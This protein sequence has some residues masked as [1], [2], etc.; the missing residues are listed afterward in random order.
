MESSIKKI[1]KYVLLVGLFLLPIFILPIF[2]NPFIVSKLSLSVGLVLILLILFAIRIALVGKLEFFVGNFDLPIL[3]IGLSFL[4]STI[5]RTPNKMEA[6]LYPGTLTAILSGVF[7]YFFINQ[8]AEEK[9]TI[10]KTLLSSGLLFSVIMLLSISDILNKIPQLPQYLRSPNFTPEGGFLPAAIFLATILPIGIGLLLSSKDIYFKI[11]WAVSSAI[12]TFTLILS[13]YKILPGK[14]LAPRFPSASTSWSIAVDSLKVSPILG[15]GPGNYLTS[16]NRFRPLS[17][18]QTD[19]WAVKFA[20]AHDFYLT[21]ITEAGL[22][23]A[24]GLI[25]LLILI[26]RIIKENIEDR[27]SLK[28][29]LKTASLV[30]LAIITLIFVLAPATPLLIILFF[31]LLSLNSNTHKAYISSTTQIDSEDKSQLAKNI[32]PKFPAL[33]ASSLII[34]GALLAA[35]QTLRIL[36]AEYKFQNALNSLARNEASKTYDTL[37]DAIATNPRVD[38][39]RSTFAQVNL[40][41]ANAI[42]QKVATNS[43]QT[44]LSDQDRQSIITLIQQAINEAKAAVALNPLRAGN[45]E[46]LGRIYRSLIPLATDADKFAIQTYTQAIALDPINP[47]LRV[48]LGGIYYS[49]KDYD[50]AVRVFELATLAKPDHANAHYN[51][52]FALR[53]RGQKGDL[54]RSIQEM[55]TVLSLV[56]KNSNDYDIAKKAL[57][58]LQAKKKAETAQGTELTAPKEEK[59]VIQPPLELPSESQPPESPLSPTP[60]PTSVSSPTPTP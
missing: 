16:F 49:R 28:N 9:E 18:N 21:S 54:D 20:T 17:Y 59:P 45:W 10:L 40:A 27:S 44:T 13:I 6:L 3:I 2:S 56:D 60:S 42:V 1:E 48:S 37:R 30:S 34:I 41:L 46:I 51:L 5:L 26:F 43:G 57:E 35:N 15:V 23:F 22:L 47:N 55:T 53:E 32:Y 25:L 58:D 50:N 4:L 19:L 29:F 52:A 8:N 12:I 38:R 31:T 39:Y 7:L 33:I 36:T 24:A 11:F 14:P